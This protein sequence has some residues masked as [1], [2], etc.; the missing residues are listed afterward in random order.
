M[1][2]VLAT[3]KNRTTVPFIFF[4]DVAKVM[5]KRK[6]SNDER[7]RRKVKVIQKAGYLGL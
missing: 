1:H 5:E 3:P 4:T 6:D 2:P 7:W